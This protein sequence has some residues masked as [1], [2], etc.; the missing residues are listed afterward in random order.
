VTLGLLLAAPFATSVVLLAVPGRARKTAAALAVLPLVGFTAWGIASAGPLLSGGEITLSLPWIPDLG[1]A[2]DLRL[3]ALG[4]LLAIV[5][6]GIGSLVV[7][8]SAAYLPADIHFP[9]FLA[10]LVAFA[11]GMVGVAAADNLFGL[12]VFW[13]VTT[14]ASYLLIGFSDDKGSAR[15]AALQAV[16]TTSVGGLAMLAGFVLLSQQAGTATLSAILAAPPSGGATTAALALILLGAFTK[17]AQVPFHGWL[18]AAMAAPTPASAYLHSATM[19]KAGVF[20]LAR[21][22]PGFGSDPIWAPVITTV[23]L[24]TMVLGAWRAL[25]QTDLKLLL[26]FGTVSQLGFMTALLGLGLVHA[27]L[28]VL[29]AH[30]LYKS[31]LFL[32]VGTIDRTAGTRDLRVLSGLGRRLPALL[33]IAAVA[34]ASKAGLPPLLG[35]AAKEAAFAEI[36]TVAAWPVVILAVAASALTVAY[37]L[38]FVWG[39]FATKAL[40]PDARPLG[41]EVPPP[42]P[43]LWAPAALLAAASAVL[44]IAP[45]W[46]D[47]LV[48]AAAGAPGKLVLWPGWQPALAASAAAVIVGTIIHLGRARAAHL[49]AAGERLLHRLRLPTA[50]GAYRR[51]L[52]GLNHLADATTGTLQHGSLPVYLGVILLAT[53]GLPAAWWLAGGVGIPAPPLAHRP[54]EVAL[55][56]LAAAAAVGAAR[57]RHR[58]TAALFLGAAGYAVGGIFVLYGAPDLALTQL[59]VETLTVAMFAFVVARLPRRHEEARLPWWRSLRVAVA[60]TVGAVVTWAAL[61]VGGGG[62]GEVSAAYLEQAVPEAGGRNVVNVILTDFR[63]LDTLGEITVLV[64]AAIGVAGL[65]AGVRVT[66]AREEGPR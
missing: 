35:W 64:V 57:A 52:E 3:D 55:G 66:S 43:G 7:V 54:A 34:A 31:A 56:L 37:A 27:A 19:V 41:A 9:R 28:A 50:D 15:A 32:V 8:Y 10:Y 26:A 2:L 47:R 29:V 36:L 4:L 33:A 17:S 51:S 53:L 16:L 42:A 21:L 14:V 5:A 58:L 30:A 12:F 46:V 62:G 39:A 22:H 44:G 40:A 61:A 23:G 13:E 1:V 48:Q 45:G 25:R 60:L 65:I 49:Q 38:R 6:T 63:A 20:L 24:A 11:G 59:L 18:P